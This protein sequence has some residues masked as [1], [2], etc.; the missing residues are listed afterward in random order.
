MTSAHMGEK[1]KRDARD[2]F[3]KHIQSL[4][5]QPVCT[6]TLRQ[7]LFFF[8]SLSAISTAL[9]RHHGQTRPPLLQYTTAWSQ[10]P[11]H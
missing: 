6:T 8:F 9:T 2:K 5:L 10:N 1:C 7:Q 4:S 11:C 3:K